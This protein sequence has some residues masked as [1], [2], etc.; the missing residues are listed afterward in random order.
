MNSTSLSLLQRLANPDNSS[1]RDAAWARFAG[2]YTPLLLAWARKQGLQD[3]DSADFVQEVLFHLSR[4]LHGYRRVEGHRFRDW[5]FT[6]VR[7]LY[8]D[9]RTQRK[10]RTLPGTDGLSGFEDTVAPD[11]VADMDEHEYRLRLTRRCL[12][13]IQG[14]FTPLTWNAFRLLAVEGRPVAEVVSELGI[15]DDAA[16]SARRR[17]VERIR[18]ELAD[19]L[20]SQ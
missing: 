2:L 6:V 5:L 10:N 13:M 11:R 15:T 16:H 4:V 1:E 8:S 9:F 12:E 14:D 18:E 20:E 17:V 19:F 7:H 3:A